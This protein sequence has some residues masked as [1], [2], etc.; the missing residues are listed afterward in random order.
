MN[1]LINNFIKQLQETQNGSGWIGENFDK[2]LNKITAKTAFLQPIN[3]IHSVAEIISHL[4]IWRQEA[5]LKINTG[6]GSITDDLE[7]NW[8]KNEQLKKIGWQQ[9]LINYTNSFNEFIELLK[10]KN[11]SFLQENYYDTDYKGNYPYQFLIEGILQHDLYHLGQIGL[12]LKLLN[13]QKNTH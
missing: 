4:T 8:F 7:A 1:L 3:S 11:H 13:N 2:K 12:V 5:I 6:K 10:T 9:L